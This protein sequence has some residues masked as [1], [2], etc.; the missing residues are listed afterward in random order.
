MPKVAKARRSNAERWKE[1]GETLK[2]KDPEQL[3]TLC[4][5]NIEQNRVN[6]QKLKMLEETE[7]QKVLIQV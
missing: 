6:R 5:H 3:E 4:A 2:E 7:R 1:Y